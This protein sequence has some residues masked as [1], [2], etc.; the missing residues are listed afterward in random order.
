MARVPLSRSAFINA[1]QSVC[2]D[3]SRECHA[4]SVR[5]PHRTRHCGEEVLLRPCA[6][7]MPSFVCTWG[8]SSLARYATRVV[9]RVC[10]TRRDATP[11]AARRK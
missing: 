9:E 8:L 5:S 1:T 2:P 11:L 6:G 10:A 4:A 7:R 3:P